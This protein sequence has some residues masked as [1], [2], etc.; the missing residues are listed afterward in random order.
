MLRTE[1]VTSEKGLEELEGPWSELLSGVPGVP[2]FLTWEW[3]STWWRHY[4]QGHSPYVLVTRDASGRLVGLAPWMRVEDRWGSLSLHRLAFLGTGIVYPAHLDLLSRPNDREAVASAVV[5]WLG[6]RSGDWDVLDLFSLAQDSALRPALAMAGGHFAEG[7]T[8]NCPYIPLPGDWTSYMMD[9][10]SAKQR[11]NLRQDGR[12]LERDYP[13]QVVFERIVDA[14]D[15]QVALS[16]LKTLH[17]KR[18]SSQG[19]TTPFEKG[20]FVDFHREMAGLALERGWL[21]F[22]RLRVGDQAI[23]LNYAF[24]Y[25]DVV[26]G[27]QKAFDPEWGRYGPGQLLQAY[28]MEEAIGEGVREID[29]LHGAQGYKSTWT[30]RARGDRRLWFSKG[31]KGRVW[32]LGAAALDGAMS[33]GREVLPDSIRQRTNR[34]L[35]AMQR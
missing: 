23:S 35:S 18:W 4:G 17:L 31:S 2:I 1:V 24:R 13:G 3:V 32:L 16:E 22:Y 8:L 14:D 33:V 5:A 34:L 19:Q 12:R 27:Y 21:R 26:Y 7:T 20:R 25:G 11:K 10:L 15:L 29:M 6:A 9:S 28:L 30:D